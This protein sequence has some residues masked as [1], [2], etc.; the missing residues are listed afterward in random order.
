MPVI[1][2]RAPWDVQHW[3]LSWPHLGWC[4]RGT[5]ITNCSQTCLWHFKT[6]VKSISIVDLNIKLYQAGKLKMWPI[7][8]PWWIHIYN[9]VKIQVPSENFWSLWSSVLQLGVQRNLFFSP[10]SCLR[11]QQPHFSH[12][13]H[14]VPHLCG[15]PHLHFQTFLP[16]ISAHSHFLAYFDHSWGPDVHLTAVWSVPR[17]TELGE[18]L[19]WPWKLVWDKWDMVRSEGTVAACSPANSLPWEEELARGG[20][21]RRL[22]E[23]DIWGLCCPGLRGALLHSHE[24]M[25]TGHQPVEPPCWAGKCE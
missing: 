5:L 2:D 10:K 17:K 3:E 22:L 6:K 14:L 21:E 13:L 23:L 1:S 4:G 16:L 25:F 20:P 19:L 7:P 11:T 8:L 15:P 12:W 9:N 18:T 24:L